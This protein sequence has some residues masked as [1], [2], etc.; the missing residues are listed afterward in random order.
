MH[1]RNTC[2]SQPFRFRFRN[3]IYKEHNMVLNEDNDKE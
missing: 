2:L 3:L 1:T